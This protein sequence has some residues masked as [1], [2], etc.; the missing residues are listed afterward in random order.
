[1]W[2]YGIFLGGLSQSAWRGFAFDPG[3]RGVPEH[4]MLWSGEWARGP[5]ARG[6]IE[7]C[8]ESPE[9]ASTPRARR[10]ITRGGTRPSSE[11]DDRSRGL[12]PLERGGGS[13]EGAPSP[14]ARRRIARGV[15][16]LVGWWAVMVSLSCGPSRIGL[17]PHGAWF[18]GSVARSFAFLWKGFFPGY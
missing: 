17:R 6:G 16:R 2:Y 13:P 1:M 11:A 4:L 18:L 10:K 8:E 7:R 9:G 12:Q 3:A 5:R 14:Q 15:S